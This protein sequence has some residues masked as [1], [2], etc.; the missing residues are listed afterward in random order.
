MA[1]ADKT[2]TCRECGAE[3]VFAAGEQEFFRSRGLLNEPGRC[4]ACRAT[5]R[6]GLLSRPE[7]QYYEV[8][9][10]SCGSQAKVPFQPRGD[11]PVYCNECFAKLR[12][13]R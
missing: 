7:Q 1:F 9:C 5:R 13:R 8:V 10:D 11:R 12:G 4:P 2:L 3:F 6:R